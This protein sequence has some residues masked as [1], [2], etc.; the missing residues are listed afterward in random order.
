MLHARQMP[1]H[2][3]PQQTPSTQFPLVHSLPALHVEAIGF[4]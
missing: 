1:L 2:V 4:F 3:D